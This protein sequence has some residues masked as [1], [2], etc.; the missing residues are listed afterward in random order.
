MAAYSISGRVSIGPRDLASVQFIDLSPLVTDEASG[1]GTRNVTSN[2]V[3]HPVPRT[4]REF[5]FRSD[6]HESV[7]LL[8]I[9]NVVDASC[10]D[11]SRAILFPPREALIL[12]P[13]LIIT[14]YL[15]ICV[16]CMYMNVNH[17]SWL[18]VINSCSF[19]LEYIITGIYYINTK[20]CHLFQFCIIVLL[21]YIVL[22]YW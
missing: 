4:N 17:Q 20:L 21:F 11:S 22:Y 13:V 14:S 12:S 16:S 5:L 15:L 19:F 6:I 8:V 1:H 10:T 18:F 2:S 9:Q 3:C 7:R